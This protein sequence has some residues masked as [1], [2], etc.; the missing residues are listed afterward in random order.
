MRKETLKQLAA[1]T[2][3]KN[4]QDGM[5]VGLGT[6]STVYYALLKL[7]E[8]VRGGLDIIGIPTSK[9]TEE[10]AKAHGIPLSTLEKHQVINVTID[11]ADEVDTGLHLIKGMGGAL[12]REKIVAHA[13]NQ[14][15]I[16]ADESKLVEALGTKSPL[17]VE[18]VPFG[19]QAT[20]LALKQLCDRIS[21]RLVN[22]APFISDNGMYILDCHFNAIPQPAQTEQ[23]INYIPGVVENG[24]FVNRAEKAIIG[25]ASGIQIREK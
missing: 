8:M 10:I 18:V 15:I 21:L 24:L 13:S 25:T 16:V 19:W 3:A 6:G 12:V 2:A 7:G 14:L 17:P 1:E 11:G 4:V 20:Q 5:V 22:N 23:I 9:Q